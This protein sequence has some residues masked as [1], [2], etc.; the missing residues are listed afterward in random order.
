LKSVSAGKITCIISLPPDEAKEV[1]DIIV[2]NPDG[3]SGDKE[4]GFTWGQRVVWE[5][6][7]PNN[8]WY[9]EKQLFIDPL[10]LSLESIA[11][12]HQVGAL[13]WRR[14]L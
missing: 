4:G 6:Y 9:N 7:R 2:K 13:L 8:L 3:R 11:R 10:N 1:W 14:S 5:V 12:T